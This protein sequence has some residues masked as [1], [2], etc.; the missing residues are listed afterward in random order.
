MKTMQTQARTHTHRNT[1][2]IRSVAIT[3][4]L[5][6]LTLAP[7]ALG[8]RAAVE[9]FVNVR[10]GSAVLVRIRLK[11]TIWCTLVTLLASRSTEPYG[12]FSNLI[13]VKLIIHQFMQHIG[14]NHVRHVGH[15]N[16]I[17]VK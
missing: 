15:E 10:C 12:N 8:G 3:E 1:F 5:I 2:L 13:R 4:T 7:G 14:T 6:S 9:S 16:F 17:S 11:L